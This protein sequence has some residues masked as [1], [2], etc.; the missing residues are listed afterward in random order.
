MLRSIIIS[1]DVELALRLETAATKT[2]EVSVNRVWNSYPTAIDLVRSLRAHAPE[3]L[4]LSFESLEK[5]QEIVRCVEQQAGGLQIIA[6]HRT[7]DAKI[8]RET[9]R[10]GVREFLSD[11]FERAL[12]IDAISHVKV[13]LE[14]K[15]SDQ[16]CAE[17]VFVVGT[18]Y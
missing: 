8:L 12:L 13:L 15:A 7:C 1:P 3:V 14:R 6:I 11:P 4:F 17:R 5:V 9:M 16:C 10:L 2:G 18:G